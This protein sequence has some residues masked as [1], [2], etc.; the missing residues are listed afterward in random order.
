MET[1]EFGNN[2][3]PNTMN[4]I[5]LLNSKIKKKQHNIT[6]KNF[7]MNEPKIKS[8]MKYNDKQNYRKY[9]IMNKHL[10]IQIFFETVIL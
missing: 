8:N 3:N 2:T 1:A 4:N 5:A 7:N 6:I 9:K 10:F